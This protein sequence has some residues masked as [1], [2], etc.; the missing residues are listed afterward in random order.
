MRLGEGDEGVESPGSLGDDLLATP[1]PAANGRED[2]PGRR[3]VEQLARE[4]AH[5]LDADADADTV[6][7]FG[8]GAT[9]RQC[10]RREL[11]EVDYTDCTLVR[12]LDGRPGGTWFL[13]CNDCAGG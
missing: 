13:F 1:A 4:L 7:I 3:R 9:C 10:G 6:P 2:E 11:D 12:N 8:F 5:E